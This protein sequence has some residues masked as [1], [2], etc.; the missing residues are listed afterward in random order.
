M[1]YTQEQDKY[2][3]QIYYTPQSPASFS[4]A[5]KLWQH[6]KS[7]PDKPDGLKLEVI[8]AW[9]KEQETH[10]IHQPPKTKFETES[11]VTEYPDYQWDADTLDLAQLVKY[12]SGFK[13]LLVVID[14]FS[15]YLWVRSMKTKSAKETLSAIESILQEG[16]VCEILRTDAGT[17]FIN[18]PVKEMLEKNGIMHITAYGQHK[19][20]YAERVNRT[21]EDRLYRYFYE[22]QTYK[23]VDII[24]DIVK[25]YN[26]TV[27]STTKMA[28]DAVNQ[29]NAAELYE[30][31]YIPILNKRAE[32]RPVYSFA[33]GDLVRLS[34]QRHPFSRGYQA[35]FTIELFKIK[36]RL[37]SH[38]PRYK[39]EDLAGETVKGSF[40]KEELLK[41]KE[42]N[43]D[44]ITFK[45]EKVLS[46]RKI[47][48]K[49]FSLVKWLGY[50]EKFNSLVPTS[51]IAK[52]K[53]K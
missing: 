33:V 43:V 48:G 51:E 40:Y 44:E 15:R 31:V 9:L 37:P 3:S 14:L 26:A 19:A 39:V 47:K 13:Y 7:R 30:R 29:D 46:K 18:K 45:I 20:N 27:H 24:D 10:A 25:S 11:I 49:Q 4:G 38:P 34:L 50:P 22:K 8:R 16:R 17:E 52:Y 35:K 1:A 6:V 42:T 41:I 23:Y 32:H 2:L 5:E 36:A 12:N 28:P 21:L 53:G